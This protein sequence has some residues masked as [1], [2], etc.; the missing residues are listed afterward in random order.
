MIN[1][2]FKA[3][4]RRYQVL[5]NFGVCCKE[6]KGLKVVNFRAYVPIFCSVSRGRKCCN[7]FGGQR[8][9]LTSLEVRRQL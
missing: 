6:L 8:S 7:F 9:V 3:Q 4:G 1:Q 5:S 2:E